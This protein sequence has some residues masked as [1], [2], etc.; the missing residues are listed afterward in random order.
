MTLSVAS[1]RSE[2]PPARARQIA[3]LVASLALPEGRLSVGDLERVV[4]CVAS[5]LDLF[6]DLVVHDVQGWSLHLFVNESFGVKIESWGEGHLINWHDHGGIF[7]SLRRDLGD[8]RR[9]VSVRRLRRHRVSP[10]A[11]RRPRVLRRRPRARRLSLP[12]A[13][14]ERA[15]LFPTPHRDDSLRSPRPGIR[16][17]RAGAR[18]PPVRYRPHVERA[19]TRPWLRGDVAARGRPVADF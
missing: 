15:R 14:A 16:R 13:G 19:L 9:T 4:A 1:I 12:G 8:A 10:T 2:A 5:R 7:G 17:T 6:E 11:R 3:E 18:D